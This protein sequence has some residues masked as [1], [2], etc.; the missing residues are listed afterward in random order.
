M[1][2]GALRSSFVGA[3]QCKHH[4]D[5]APTGAQPRLSGQRSI[6]PCSGARCRRPSHENTFAAALRRSAPGNSSTERSQGLH[7]RRLTN[8]ERRDQNI[9]YV[10]FCSRLATM[11]SMGVASE[12][13]LAEPRSAAQQHWRPMQRCR[14]RD[15]ASVGA[16]A[17]RRPR[18]GAPRGS[19]RASAGRR[20]SRS[21][22]EGPR[23]APSAACWPASRPSRP[24]AWAVLPAMMSFSC[25]SSIVS[26]LMSASAI[27]CSLSSAPTRICLRA[28]EVALD[29][30][31]AL[32]RRSRAR[33]R[34][35]P[36]C[37]A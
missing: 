12:K 18:V 26:Y 29:H 30:A 34:P 14:T 13:R 24:A 22:A 3:A 31:C 35:T 20:A 19:T 1:T 28:L 21:E 33:C 6:E 10:T 2:T 17:A 36:A 27:A 4:A 23:R 8:P 32:P 7:S 15:V 5:Y 16:S 25:S 9:S 37:A 11:A